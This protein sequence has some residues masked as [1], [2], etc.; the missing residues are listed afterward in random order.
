MKQ[1]TFIKTKPTVISRSLFIT[2]FFLAILSLPGCSKREIS[3]ATITPEKPLAKSSARVAVSSINPGNIFVGSAF[4]MEEMTKPN[5]E[6]WQTIRNYGVGL[7]VHPVGWRGRWS[8]IGVPITAMLINKTFTYEFDIKDVKIYD[9]IDNIVE[10]ETVRSFGLTCARVQCN[11]SAKD[12]ILDADLPNYLL[13]NVVKPF[14]DLDDPIAVDILFSPVSGDAFDSVDNKPYYEWLQEDARWI[15]LLFNQAHAQGVA[16][17]FP[18]SYWDAQ[19]YRN[20]LVPFLRQAKAHN[21]EVTLMLNFDNKGTNNI[22][23]LQTIYHYLENEDLL[24]ARWVVNNFGDASFLPVPEKETNCELTNRPAGAA[25]WLCKQNSLPVPEEL[26][27]PDQTKYYKI[28]GKQSNKCIDVSY[29]STQ[30]NAPVWIWN[31]MDGL[32]QQWR[33]VPTGNGY[34]KIIS[35]NSGLCLSVMD[36]SPA[37]GVNLVQQVDNN[38]PNQQWKIVSLCKGYYKIISKNS[39]KCIDVQG[40][41]TTDG[42]NIWQYDYLDEDN[43]K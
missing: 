35:K 28:V 34:Y 37:N 40:Y 18:P 10:V 36:L 5:A 24:P 7:H 33:F 13:E 16:L 26:F 41:S 39:G 11:V 17:D 21:K 15:D 19:V 43:Q 2:T 4:H 38:T 22:Q 3:K 6:G 31:Y 30:N 8:A 42:G 27:Y 9:D 1:K 20:A 12:L 32:N 25:L 14:N 23:N 29:M